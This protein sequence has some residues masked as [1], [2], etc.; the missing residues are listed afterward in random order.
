M[1]NNKIIYLKGAT[2]PLKNKSQLI[3]KWQYILKF[4]I[5]FLLLFIFMVFNLV[6][7]APS[8]NIFPSNKVI[9]IDQGLNLKEIGDY[10]KENKVIKSSL[11]FNLTIRFLKGEKGIKAGDYL[12][13]KPYSGFEIAEKIING[14]FGIEYKKILI[15][16]G[17]TIY[18]I[19][20][21]LEKEGLIKKEELYKYSGCCGGKTLASEKMDFN[22]FE[23]LNMNPFST[24]LEGYFFPDTYYFPI[25]IK[26]DELIRIILKNFNSKIDNDLKDKINKSG[27]GFYNT[28]IVASILEKEAQTYEDKKIVADILW[29]RIQKNMPLQVDAS[30]DYVIGKNTF[31]LTKADLRT[32]SP[33]NT[34]RFK[35]LPLTPISNPGLD[36]LRAAASPT[37]NFYW[38]Y[39]SDYGNN[40]HY[41]ETYDEHKKNIEE[42]LR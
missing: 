42:Y 3:F 19:S 9:K 36:S 41:S 25:N 8:K 21:M 2:I 18:E 1:A 17:M 12:F 39:L 38:Y 5:A 4:L 20:D 16:E 35:G 23:N 27:K 32:N 14:D 26:P 40:M 34:Y 33:Y 30:L 31:E 24:M 6:F 28:L 22:E 7:M 37:P 10:L 13:S 29:R 11:V 15:K